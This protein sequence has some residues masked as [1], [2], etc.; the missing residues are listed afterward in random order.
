MGFLDFF[1]SR[2]SST[3]S[4]SIA[5]EDTRVPGMQAPGSNE[6][7]MRP[8][9]ENAVKYLYRELW[10]D[11]ELRQA[12]VDIRNVDRIDGRVKQ[13]HRKTARSAAK[14]GLI[15]RVN[16]GPKSLQ[17]EWNAFAQRCE[18]YRTEKLYSDLRGLM[19]EGNLAMQWVLDGAGNVASGVRMPAETILPKVGANGRFVDVNRAY[20]QID[21]S[22]LAGN[23]VVASFAL[24]QLTLGRIDPDN[25]DD[26]GALGRPYL[27]ACRPVWKK[28]VMTEED[29]VVRRRMR[30]PL[31][32]AHMLEG[33]SLEELAA[34]QIRTE[35]DQAFGAY[36]DYYA[37]KKGA[38][39]PI[40]GDANLEQIADVAYLL[41]TF[42]AGAPAPKGLFGLGTK[43]LQRDILEDLKKDYFDEIDALQDTCSS[44]YEQGFRLH[45]LL[46]GKNP[47][48]YD[49]S[50]QFLERRTDT[51]NQRADL[52]LKYQALGMSRATVFESTGIDVSAEMT[53]LEQQRADHDP[54][55]FE[56]MEGNVI[57]G[58]V[59]P[60]TKGR[61]RPKVS[62]TPGNAPKGESATTIT[63]GGGGQ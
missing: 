45:L 5:R 57:P 21:L 4:A 54:Y 32:M 16:D 62:V 37:N 50:V 15:L 7:G 17:V 25:Y 63:N 12:I 61:T 39:T 22:G 2:K 27:D 36:K 20:D 38:V 34:Y 51:P 44:V 49:Y 19:M 56:G 60:A 33:A 35:Q 59:P 30:A 42:F 40:E 9:P 58:E 47:N 11:P 24:W 6:R 53:R 18:L 46:R 52:A 55:P 41:D 14:G 31:R 10:V 43:E 29:L 26:W 8:N 48:A 13:I 3:G 1:R 28:L 23:Q